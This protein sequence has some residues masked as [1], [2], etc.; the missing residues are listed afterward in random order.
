M[1]YTNTNRTENLINMSCGSYM[2]DHEDSYYFN[3]LPLV[4]LSSEE[5]AIRPYKIITKRARNL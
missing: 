3:K 4:K 5:I 2:A 1:I